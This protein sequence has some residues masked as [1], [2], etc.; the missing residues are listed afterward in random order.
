[1]ISI[2][3]TSNT[4]LNKSSKSGYPCFLPKIRGITFKFSPLNLAFH[5]NISCGF[6]IFGL[7]FISSLFLQYLFIILNF[8]HMFWFWICV[9]L[10]FSLFLFTDL[11]TGLIVLSPSLCLSLLVTFFLFFL[12][13]LVSINFFL[14]SYLINVDFINCLKVLSI[15]SFLS[16]G[17]FD[18]FLLISLFSLLCCVACEVLVLQQSVRPEL[19]RWEIQ[20]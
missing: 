17:W 6:V 2:A 19:P 14:C 5:H 13:L 11:F 10:V 15:C 12:F 1:M 20:I 8:S 9:T 16:V 3:E 4:V 18:F 7:Y